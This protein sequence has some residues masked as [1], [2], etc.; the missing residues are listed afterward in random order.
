M[1][2]TCADPL[3]SSLDGA[4]HCLASGWPDNYLPTQALARLR[5]R[6][7]E[8]RFQLAVL[9]QFK[10]GKSTFINGL[11]GTEVLPSAVLPLT[12]I[13]TFIAWGAM[14]RVRVTYQGNRSAEDF[15]PPST[16]DV[17]E[18]LRNFV[19]EEGNPANARGVARV[20]LFLP[21]DILRNG[22]VLIDTPGIG[23]TL[24]HNTDTALQVLPECDAALLVVS[25]D[26]P[27]TEAEIAYLTEIR[28]HV[29]RLFYVLNKIDYLDP[30][31]RVQIEDF[32]R[33]TL[34]ETGAN[35][36]NPVIFQLSA[37]QALAARMNADEASL[38]ASGLKR[39]EREIVRYLA[40]EKA[41]SLRMS[42]CR[43]AYDLVDQALADL[44]VRIRAL[45][46]P[47][48]DLEQRAATFAEAL[49]AFEAERRTAQ[50]LL[51]GDR[52]RVTAE[53]EAQAERLRLDGRDHVTA[54]MQ[55]AITVNG[56][57][58]DMPQV[59]RVVAETIPTFFDAKLGGVVTAFRQSVERIVVAH[60]ARTDALVA[61]V[62]RTAADLFD[63]PFQA[64]DTMEPFRLGPEPY[65]VTQEERAVLMPSPAAFLTRLLPAGPRERRLRKRLEGEIVSLVQRNVE[66]LRWATLRG[67]TE[68]FRRFAVQL[69]ENLA[70]A[71]DATQGVIGA[72]LDRRQSHA[73]ETEAELARLQALY[74]RL[75]HCRAELGVQAADLS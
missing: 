6:L 73:D 39:I 50:D 70:E 36:Q 2:D 69:D 21:A 25:A 40:H 43:K 51:A 52:T 35:E 44:G 14:P 26:P 16:R 74:H 30:T 34:R 67:L 19:T 33:K 9:G 11:L 64:A 18:Q 54:A 31:E 7:L 32:L 60:Q 56:G 28:A 38:E 15:H 10:R 71:F 68:T 1:A 75:E 22:V 42:V 53:L 24:Q 23:S 48:A 8:A 41:T 59:H 45:E 57:S 62:R 13:A 17:Q 46:L 65:W 58:I 29:V 5:Q 49:R 61:T 4:R 66:N 3:L 47:L 20:D 63:V 37:R 27:I 12:A 55:R 72:A